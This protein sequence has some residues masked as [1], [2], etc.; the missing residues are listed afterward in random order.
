MRIQVFWVLALSS[1]VSFI[2]EISQ[3]CPFF[4]VHFK[5]HELIILKLCRATLNTQSSIS[6]PQQPQISKQQSKTPILYSQ[7]LF[8]PCFYALLI[9]SWPNTYTSNVSQILCHFRWSPQKCKI[10]VS[11]YIFDVT[12]KNLQKCSYQF[13]TINMQN[14][15]I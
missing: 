15:K 6:T 2:P 3:E 7:N 5:K 11:L 4:C 12:K 9:R 13:V 10:R 14:V 8:F 1:R